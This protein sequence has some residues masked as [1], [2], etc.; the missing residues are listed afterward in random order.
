MDLE[1]IFNEAPDDVE[2]YCKVSNPE[3]PI[4]N[5]NMCNGN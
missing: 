5:R 4:N 3:H 2:G 1:N